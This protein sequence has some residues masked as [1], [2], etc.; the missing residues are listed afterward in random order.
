MVAH[1]SRWQILK[2]KLRYVAL[3]VVVL[4]FAAS[5]ALTLIKIRTEYEDAVS[6]YQTTLWYVSQIEFEFSKFLNALDQLGT[7]DPAVSK[8]ELMQRFHTLNRN[9]PTLVNGIKAASAGDS[10]YLDEGIRELS[11]ILV[12]LS[13]PVRELQAGD[14][15][16][17]LQIRGIV[18]QGLRPLRSM[19]SETERRERATFNNRGSRIDP[20]YTEITLYA[21]GAALAGAILIVLLI[22][23]VRQAN[24]LRDVAESAK[25]EAEE[26]NEAKSRFLAMMSHE[27]RTPMNGVLGTA[28][29]LLDTPLDREQRE[30]VDTVR[31]SGQAL[32]GV[33]NDI[34]D[35]SKIEAGKL[36]LEEDDVPLRSLVSEVVTLLAAG[37]A[38]KPVAIRSDVEVDVAEVVRADPIRL[39]QILF[40]LA[41]NAVKFTEKGSVVIRVRSTAAAHG[42]VRLR[43]EVQDTGIGIPEEHQE[44]LF[45][46]FQQADSSISRRFGGTGLGLAISRRLVEAMGGE[47]GCR[48][49]AG[50]G[51]T[52]WFEISAEAGTRTASEMLPQAELQDAHRSRFAGARLLL[53]ED[54]RINELVATKMLARA[55]F[56]VS[57]ARD[58]G[59]AVEM[60][61]TGEYRLVLMDVQ[62]PD[63][64]GYEATRLIRD[65]ERERGSAPMP[66]LAMTAN[67]MED[68][69]RACIEAGMDGFI[70]KPVNRV[71]MIRQIDD[72][73]RSSGVPEV[74]DKAGVP[75]VA[76]MDG[77]SSALPAGDAVLL[78][79]EIFGQF[80]D[81]V[82]ADF[83]D[84]IVEE[85]A[86]E[87]TGKVSAIAAA[88]HSREFA[89]AQRLSHSLKSGAGTFGAVAL[90]RCA[91]RI[92]AASRAEDIEALRRL[93]A[94]LIELADRSLLTV[95]NEASSAA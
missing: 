73:L 30:Y 66:V 40:N 33:L 37:A 21:V 58:G 7:G 17:Y 8:E 57:V 22:R 31:N 48:S 60:A 95:R 80:S 4:V 83:R 76:G 85:F 82:G 75:E 49:R 91:E 15:R 65:E 13:V 2:G 54:D 24:T 79:R 78:D 86:A 18:E 35:F 55:G 67:P 87:T 25:R 27:I 89:E 14:L 68:N 81:D 93:H 62:L 29:L 42:R 23:Q 45:Q 88:I 77:L 72:C 90:Q 46:E 61:R 1:L 70:P 74:A 20:F 94:E 19:I 50:L 39:R 10:G 12:R 84:E 63:M 41:G 11:A 3:A 32:L 6:E 52:F 69:R 59:S 26:A 92:E 64:D 47:I 34:L 53:V 16:N 5:A 36:V 28:S 38:G 43:F 51:S 56:E 9:F 71:G 44:S